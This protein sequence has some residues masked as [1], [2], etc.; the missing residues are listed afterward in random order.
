MNY[1]KILAVFVL[2]FICVFAKESEKVKVCSNCIED[3]K[4]TWIELKNGII[5]CQNLGEFD[6]WTVR[7]IYR[8]ALACQRFEVR[9]GK[10]NC[11]F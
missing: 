11:E 10:N 8:N 3:A 1:Y 4:C 6:P 9:R 5:F 7:T 2:H